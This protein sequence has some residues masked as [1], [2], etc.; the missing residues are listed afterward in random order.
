MLG[1]R[2]AAGR[3]GRAS[4]VCR[5]RDPCPFFLASLPILLASRVY[6]YVGYICTTF[7]PIN[8]SAFSTKPS[9]V[10]II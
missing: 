7:E 9:H 4:G 1:G 10:C 3:V 2:Q 8:V 6:A 5:G